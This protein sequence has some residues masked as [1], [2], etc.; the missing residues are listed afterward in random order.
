MGLEIRNWGDIRR[1]MCLGA[2]A[3]APMCGSGL[4]AGECRRC[5]GEFR[6][7]VKQ[8]REIRLRGLDAYVVI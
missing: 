2:V 7:E 1:D 6:A 8:D 5:T 4:G 3:K